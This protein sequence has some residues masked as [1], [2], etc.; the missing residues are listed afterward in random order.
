MQRSGAAVLAVALLLLGALLAADAS[1][2]STLASTSQARRLFGGPA[3]ELLTL[4]I[5]LQGFL[6]HRFLAC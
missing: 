5:L 6:Q 1:S 3:G 4:A 2:I